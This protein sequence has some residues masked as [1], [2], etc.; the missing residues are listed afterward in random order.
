M[1]RCGAG[2]KSSWC[3]DLENGYH[4]RKQKVLRFRLMRCLKV[5]LRR[6]RLIHFPRSQL[7]IMFNNGPAARECARRNGEGA[8][9]S[10]EDCEA[11]SAVPCRLPR[12]PSW[13]SC[14]SLALTAS[15]TASYPLPVQSWSFAHRKSMRML[16]RLSVSQCPMGKL[17]KPGV[18]NRKRSPS[19]LSPWCRRRGARQVTAI[20]VV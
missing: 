19:C 7:Q 10:R 14:A 5:A 15:D 13:R 1:S 20:S 2:R 18:W 4:F 3:C 16:P 12:H 9:I 6:R 17:I 11:C 8:K